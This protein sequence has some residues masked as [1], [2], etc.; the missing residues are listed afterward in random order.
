VRSAPAQAGAVLP[1]RVLHEFCKG[2][3]IDG[4]FS[5]RRPACAGR[6]REAL[7]H[8]HARRPLQFWGTAG[9]DYVI[10]ITGYS[11]NAS[12]IHFV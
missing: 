3:C 8:D 5:A 6:H 7:R 1:Y 12:Q 10:D 11:G 4:F 9:A 2:T